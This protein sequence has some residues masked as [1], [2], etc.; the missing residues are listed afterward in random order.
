ML[1]AQ[2][3]ENESALVYYMPKTEI[4]FEVQYDEITQERG[5]FYQYSE[6]YLGTKD[7]VTEDGT[8]YRLTNV[9]VNTR[10]SADKKRTYIIP[11]NQKTL[12]NCA[13]RLNKKGLLEGI[14]LPE[15][16]T[17]ANTNT[18]KKPS[19]MRKTS[20][21]KS[22]MP[23]L[24]DQMLSGSVGKMAEGTAKLIYSIR[25]NRL[26]L[27]AGDVEHTP[28]DGT[29]M[30]LVLAE[31]D[32]QE[33]ALTELFIGKTTVKH[34]TKKIYLLPQESTDEQVLFRFST[35]YGPVDADDMS[36]EPYL[37]TLK[38]EKQEAVY[39]PDQKA[40]TPSPF[41]Q[42]IPGSADILLTDG[43]KTLVKTNIPVAQFGI[44][45]PLAADLFGKKKTCVVFDTRTGSVREVK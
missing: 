34:L 36:G 4:V 5:V 12:A 20:A 32:E 7:V 8:T 26:N 2:V 39:D 18:G 21:K 10:T 29:A 17:P 33:Q 22:V 37:L 28:S 11:A 31:M 44:A 24:E 6:R 35:H 16:E 19:D 13:V 42:N 45:T 25:E 9:S 40:A 23:L 38:A 3:K 15:T 14:N 41:Y 43:E 27:L 30:R 1:S